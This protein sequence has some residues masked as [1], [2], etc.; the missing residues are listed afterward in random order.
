MANLNAP[1]GFSPVKQLTGAP[2][3][4]QINAYYVPA[5]DGTAIGIGDVVKLA[6]GTTFDA[7][8]NQNLKNVTRLTTPAT[9]VPV[10]VVVGFNFNPDNLMQKGRAA[11]TARIVYVADSPE[12]LFAA[13][14]DATGI[15]AANIGLNA[16][17]TVGTVDAVTGVTN[18][19]VTGPA[20]TATLPLELVGFDT[21]QK[22]ETGPYARVLVRFNKHQYVTGTTGV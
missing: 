14:S 16:T 22:N 21:T 4:N 17:I 19:V 2:F 5:T 1:N 7:P 18:A 13:Q 3:N 12:T 20:A 15:A 11:N 9:D 10:G 8:S 6:A